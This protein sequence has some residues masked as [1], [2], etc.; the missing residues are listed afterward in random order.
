[1]KNIKYYVVLFI[2]TL[3]SCTDYLNIVPD[4]ILEITSMFENREKA[5]QALAACY[6]Y[7]PK[8]QYCHDNVA[9]LG[10]EYF[11]HHDAA[12]YLKG[13]RIMRGLQTPSS[14][15]L[16]FWE[17]KNGATA[18]YEGIRKCNIFLEH[19]NL[20]PD[21]L[22][23]EYDDF[24]AQA[25]FLKGYFHFLLV[26]HYGPVV[27]ADKNLELNAPMEEIWQYR[28]PMNKCFDYILQQIDESI[29]NLKLKREK[30]YLG[31]IDKVAAYGIK[32]KILVYRASPL[33]NGNV[34]FYS[35]LLD[36][37][38]K[39][40]LFPMDYDPEL[41]KRAKDALK[42]AINIAEESGITLYHYQKPFREYDQED[43]EKSEILKTVYDLKYSFVDPWNEELIWGRSNVSYAISGATLQHAAQT[44]SVELPNEGKFS[45][46]WLGVNNTMLNLY[47][48]KNGLPIEEDL[49]YD[50]A[51]SMAIGDI[52]EDNYHLGLMQQGNGKRTV[53]IHLD[54]EPRFYAWIATDNSIWRTHNTK[55]LMNTR[56]NGIPGGYVKPDRYQS[57]TACKK[58]VHPETENTYF[59]RV[60]TYP[61]PLL[62]LADLYL[63]YAE[64]CNE[65]DGPSQEVYSQL[66]KIRNRAGLRNIED[67]WSDPSLA[68]SVG[69]HTTQ[70]GLREII[71][72]ERMIE[73][74]FEGH[75]Y[76]D[77]RRWK[78]ADEFYLEPAI[79]W[80]ETQTAEDLFYVTKP[81]QERKW[82]TPRDYL[83]PI[84]TNELNTNPN[85]IQNV[86]W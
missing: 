68:R 76:N 17:G 14:V 34:E 5:L 41:W 58:I 32:A 69:K 66:N 9:L 12:A 64:A 79:G 19:A 84:S 56:K 42:E 8:E 7:L 40:P 44:R 57:C 26:C 39:E 70:D 72:Q 25:K 18:L 60:V 65:Y 33:F 83:F 54:R 22:A 10:N 6:S 53:K 43:V 23:G 75:Q 24:C 45:Y 47:Y 81:L 82:E 67:V 74:S 86:G 38:T 11:S 85:L 61:W 80:D 55:L 46:Q 49:T 35:R 37:V 51:N 20:V 27:I 2:M 73:L 29:P 78:R 28:Q 31:Q 62:R 13:M 50:F 21:F 59:H 30:A 15:T 63:M 3:S 36:P 52:P 16:N 71:H 4:N 77:I 1:M 48:S